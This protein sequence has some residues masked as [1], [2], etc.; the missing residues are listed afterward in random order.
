ML[1]KSCEKII[2][3][4]K[5]YVQVND[6]SGGKFYFLHAFFEKN[7]SIKYSNKTNTNKRKTSKPTND[8]ILREKYARSKK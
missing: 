4:L 1:P 8:R 6:R 2:L 7:A 3:N 5:F